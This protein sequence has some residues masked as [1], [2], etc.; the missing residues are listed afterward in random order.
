MILKRYKGS[1]RVI[2]HTYITRPPIR[3]LHW[4]S[5]GWHD[6]RVI[7]AG[8]GIINGY[9]A[10]LPFNGKSYAYNPTMPPAKRLKG[11]YGTVLISRADADKA[12]AKN[13]HKRP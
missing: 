2:S 7:V 13:L 12:F 8:G 5:H 3:V 10:D 4:T 1:W 11:K 6:L 9:E